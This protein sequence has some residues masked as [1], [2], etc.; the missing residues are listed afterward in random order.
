[1][2]IT[3]EKQKIVQS[4]NFDSVNCTI[5]AEDMRYV[6]SLLRNNYSNTR[7]AVVRE[8]SANALDANTEAGSDRRI[9]ISVPTQMHPNFSVRDFG[10]GLSEE[11]IFGLYSKYGKSTKRESNN[12]IGAFGI[13][14][15]A[16]LSYGDSFTCVSFH[17][18]M[19]T[20]YNVFVNDDDDTKIARI[21]EP[22]PTND[23][24]GLK[25]EVAVADTDISEFQDFVKSFFK[26]FG[27]SEMP[28]FLGV[29]PD[30]IPTPKITLTDDENS[31]FFLESDRSYYYRSNASVLMGRVAYP[32]DS[33]AIKV[34]NFIS[35][36]SLR[37]VVSNLLHDVNFHF[38]LPLGSV[39][40]HHSRESLEYNKSTQKEICRVLVGI[41]KEIKVIAVAKLADSTCLYMAKRNYA[42][43]V[44][45][46]PQGISHVMK[47]SFEWQSVQISSPQWSRDY[48]M[49]DDLIITRMEKS[50]DKDSRN[51]F[52]VQSQKTTRVIAEEN[53]VFMIQDLDSA[54]G[55]NLRARTL[56]N[57]DESLQIVYVIHPKNQDARDY[58]DNSWSFHLINEK[59]LF[60][61]S[62][63]EKEKITR[64]NVSGTKS[65]ATIPVFKMQFGS[66]YVYRN[67][68]YW[69]DVK[70][71][72]NSMEMDSVDGKYK[73]KMVYAPI[74]NFKI[75]NEEFNLENVH[76]TMKII[77]AK[78]D[79]VFDDEGNKLDQPKVE[80]FGVRTKDVSKL[81]KDLWMSFTDVYVDFAKTQMRTDKD[82][83]FKAYKAKTLNASSVQ[84]D[85]K[86]SSLL[87]KSD[88][89]LDFLSSSHPIKMLHE[90]YHTANADVSQ[91]NIRC[92]N[93]LINKEPKWLENFFD[94]S[95]DVDAVRKNVD[96]VQKTYPLLEIISSAIHAWG[97]LA[98]DTRFGNVKDKI[99]DYVSLCD[100]G[101]GE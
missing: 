54:H 96:H 69:E 95:F 3:Q 81:D 85:F 94:Y 44:N 77:R 23:P 6:A 51:G 100:R 33:N 73:G 89:D 53:V 9:E 64:N 11:D 48:E 86:Y 21:G 87:S 57:N 14:K 16:P 97:N 4:H 46:L 30:F 52:R 29:E 12:Y 83:A 24:T 34:E 92:V 71:P 28:K 5:D 2:I 62:E 55:N 67:A 63:V 22:E 18:G 36:E 42:T 101:E 49:Q 70:N 15:F 40:L 90:H 8:I 66:R 45:S 32:I 82:N 93:L 78:L 50:A 37:K 99:R 13:G 20:T 19:K 35:D 65:R 88:S 38:R 10:G 76:A 58:M 17:N 31:W 41:A 80:L 72:I 25:I 26:F 56:F 61:T 68:D 79:D 98:E 59:Y 7:L 1:M 43:I 39:K 84:I 60:N 27:D 75:D 74:K 91:L 47:D